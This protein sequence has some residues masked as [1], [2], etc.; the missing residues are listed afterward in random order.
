MSLSEVFRIKTHPKYI[1][2]QVNRSN[3]NNS[4]QKKHKKKFLNRFLEQYV[5]ENWDGCVNRLKKFIAENLAIK[6]EVIIER[7]HRIV[8]SWK[9]DEQNKNRTIAAK[10]L[11]F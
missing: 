6:E 10:F 8:E 9:N 2:Q 5:V 1:T 3:K 11:N 4:G 7:T